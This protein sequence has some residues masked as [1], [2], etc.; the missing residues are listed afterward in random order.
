HD[1]LPISLYREYSTFRG[2]IAV[3]DRSIAWSEPVDGPFRYQRHYAEGPLYAHVTGYYGVVHGRTG[4]E[5]AENEVL[6]GSA[7]TLFLRRLEDLVTGR[8]QPGAA[9]ALALAP[10][11]QRA[12]LDA[13]GGRSGAVAALDRRT[14]AILA[15]VSTPGFGPNTMATHDTAAASAT[16]RALLEDPG[17]PLVNR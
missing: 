1:A 11:A 5:R 6:P 10:A 14:G 2:P 15:M 4:I 16:Y 12:A 3:G 7:S 17:D 8:Q 13:L 9:V